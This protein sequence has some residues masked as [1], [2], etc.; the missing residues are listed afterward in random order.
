MCSIMGWC[1]PE[2]DITLFKAGFAETTSRGPDMSRIEETED[3]ILGF[4][5]LAIM[6]LHPEGM[7]PFTLDGDMAVCNGEIYGFQALKEQLLGKYS[8]Q[9]DSDCEILLPLW[10]EYGTEMFAMLDAEFAC[11]I[12]D[13]DSRDFIAARD[14]IGIRPLYFGYDS[15]GSIVFASEPKNLVGLCSSIKPF[16][17]GH[18]YRNGVFTPYCKIAQVTEVCG[19]DVE[20][21]CKNIREKLIAGVR[22]RL[23]ADA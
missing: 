23:V 2:A 9:S 18:Y 22:K 15:S 13:S 8:F 1:S 3:G 21:A 14:P 12:Y 11:V 6:G 17:P 10:K 5:R 7:Q 19:D 4:H 20:T 16:P